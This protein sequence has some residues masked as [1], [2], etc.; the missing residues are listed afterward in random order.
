MV[1]DTTQSCKC[2]GLSCEDLRSRRVIPF[3]CAEQFCVHYG[4][5][6][7]SALVPEVPEVSTKK[8][9]GIPSSRLHS[10]FA[11]FGM[12]GAKT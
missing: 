9:T 12:R 1:M 7:L 6:G 8:G 4:N 10:S 3:C 2:M 11:D 5:L